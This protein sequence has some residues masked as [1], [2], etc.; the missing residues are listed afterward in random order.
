[1]RPSWCPIIEC[2]TKVVV[3]LCCPQLSVDKV[4][5]PIIVSNLGVEVHNGLGVLDLDLVYSGL[6]FK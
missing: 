4:L 3:R 1:M 5:S 2:R 6:A